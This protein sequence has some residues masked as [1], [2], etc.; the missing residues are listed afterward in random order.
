MP[1]KAE[2]RVLRRDTLWNMRG[3]VGSVID[4]NDERTVVKWDDGWYSA[5]EDETELIP[6]HRAKQI[7]KH[8]PRF[9]KRGY[10]VKDQTNYRARR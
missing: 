7:I 10:Y 1:L 4:S 5:I 6:I 3:P 9:N 8:G 2:T